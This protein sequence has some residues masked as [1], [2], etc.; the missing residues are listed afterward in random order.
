MCA[1]SV[2][3]LNTIEITWNQCFQVKCVISQQYVIYE[4]EIQKGRKKKSNRQKER[5]EEKKKYLPPKNHQ[6]PESGCSRKK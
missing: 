4:L 3:G 1:V 5:K 6:I 2:K